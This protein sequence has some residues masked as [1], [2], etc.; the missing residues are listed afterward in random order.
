MS[1]NLQGLSNKLN[2]A[3]VAVVAMIDLQ[4]CSTACVYWHTVVVPDQ[5]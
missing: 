5:L 3:S 1:Y 4:V 2:V